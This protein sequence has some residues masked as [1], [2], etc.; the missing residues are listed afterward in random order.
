MFKWNRIIVALI[1]IP[2]L[3]FV[4]LDRQFHGIPL[5]VFTN[6]V[7]GVGV[8]EFY[9]M[10]KASG[11]EV[12]DKFGILISLLIPNLIFAKNFYDLRLGEL[13][14]IFIAAILI[15][16][17]RI[18]INK[19]KGSLESTAF[20]LLGIIYVSCFFSQILKIYN[21]PINIKFNY[22]FL[23]FIQILV[24]ASDTFAGV[25]GVTFG[26]KIFKK[27]FTE[28]SPKKSVEGAIGSLVLTGVTA[29][30]FYKIF[31]IS[32]DTNVI[33]MSFFVGVFISCVSQIG[34][35]IES[36]FKRECGVKDSG[37]ILMG[38]GG[39]LDRFDSMILVVPVVYLILI[40]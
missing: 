39:V 34:D 32:S 36:L 2:L 17:H 6:F 23:I 16:A 8:Y 25:V 30:I 35:L 13:E 40:I 4:Y 27:G 3:L 14:I 15:L 20:T 7:V 9:K 24:W 33:Y 22:L 5:L 18:F 21:L 12:Y 29:C 1:G 38:H 11:K 31:G 26:R 19:I 10:L 28:I 37:T